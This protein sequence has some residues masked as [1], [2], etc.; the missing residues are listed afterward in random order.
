MWLDPNVRI[1]T[2]AVWWEDRGDCK[3]RKQEGG[4]V[5]REE[6]REGERGR[7]REYIH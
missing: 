1:E 7:D 6:N 4:R 2:V 3:R 5:E